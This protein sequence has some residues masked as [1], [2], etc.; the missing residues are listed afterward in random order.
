MNARHAARQL[1]L[2]TLFQMEKQGIQ[3]SDRLAIHDLIIAS[4]RS[5]VDEARNNIQQAVDGLVAVQEALRE[6]EHEHPDNLSTPLD[7]PI[8]PVDFPNTEQLNARVES[9]LK[10]AEWLF[11]A[12]DL[13][14]WTALARIQEV[15]DYAKQ[16]IQMVQTNQAELD[17]AINACSTDWRIDRLVQ[18]DATILRLAAAE[19]KYQPEVDV[20]VSIDEAVELAK[21]FSTE[22]SYKFING[23][24]G[25]L[26]TQLG[27]N[28]TAPDDLA[29][30]TA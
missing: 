9:C 13:P 18:I 10:S 11:D 12:I 28:Y 3:A 1:A 8:K 25:A 29:T 17:E 19:M 26:A 5:L 30:K 16:L 15:Q 2:L 6:I 7:A 21:R 24:L 4:V 23:V 27:Y 14:E 22:D 20:S